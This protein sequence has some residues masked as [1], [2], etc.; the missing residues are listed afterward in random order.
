[1]LP[2]TLFHIWHPL[3]CFQGSPQQGGLSEAPPRCSEAQEAC[4]SQ[5]WLPMWA[6][7]APAGGYPG[8]R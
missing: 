3:G 7:L 2:T 1:M 4:A 5:G 8:Q 6:L